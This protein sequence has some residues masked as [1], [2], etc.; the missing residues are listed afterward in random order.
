MKMSPCELFRNVPFAAVGSGQER[1]RQWG[2]G[3][4]AAGP[5]PYGRCLGLRRLYPI[6]DRTPGLRSRCS[7]QKG[8]FSREL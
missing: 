4:Y 6:G 8:T 3:R 2:P 1:A 5:E 7:N